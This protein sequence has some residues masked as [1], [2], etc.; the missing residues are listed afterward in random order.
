[1]RQSVN[2]YLG[3]LEALGIK[4]VIQNHSS[5]LKAGHW[6]GYEPAQKDNIENIMGQN[7]QKVSQD[8]AQLQ[9]QM[10]QL[11]NQMMLMEGGKQALEQLMNVTKLRSKGCQI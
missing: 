5:M 2:Y 6:Y 7:L 10:Q 1:M 9:Q 3:K 8:L 11:Q 4:I